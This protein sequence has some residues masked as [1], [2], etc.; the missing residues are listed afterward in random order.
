[1]SRERFHRFHDDFCRVCA[2]PATP[3]VPDVDGT[4]AFRANTRGCTVQ[5]S[6]APHAGDGDAFVVADLGEIAARDEALVCKA[7]LRANLMLFGKDSPA[8][9]LSARGHLTVQFT[10]PLDTSCTVELHRRLLDLVELSERLKAGD[11][12]TVT[13]RHIGATPP[14]D[15]CRA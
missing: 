9:G 13:S 12:A 14:L 1:M 8:F 2:V 3:L 5:V 4:I 11:L 7:L 6:H 10:L 15:A